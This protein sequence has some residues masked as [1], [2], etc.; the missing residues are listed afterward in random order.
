LSARVALIAL[1]LG[2]YAYFYQAGGW[3][4]NSRIDLTRAIVEQ[5]TSQIDRYVASTG[6]E[7]MTFG[8][9][10][11][12]RRVRDAHHYCDKAPGQSWMA[13]PPFGAA[14]ALGASVSG[15]TW[16]ATVVTVAVPSA[17]A[18]VLIAMLLV[19]WGV[20]DGPA[21]LA[22]LAWAFATLAFPY[23]TLFYGHQTVASL[24]VIGFAMI[25]IPRARAVAPSTL[26][27][28][29]AGAVLG[30]AV[31]VEYPAALACAIIGGYTVYTC[32]W[33]RALWVAAGALPP[34]ICAALYHW[35]LFG[36]PGTTAYTFSTQH[37]R[38]R[39]FFM[40]IGV[41]DPDALWRI[42][43]STFRGLFFTAPWLLLAIP[44]GILLGKRARGPEIAVCASIF[45]LFVWLNASLVDWNGGWALGPR[46]LVPCLPFVVLLAA[47]IL[48]PPRDPARARD[49]ARIVLLAIAGVLVA[50]A[51][52]AMLVGTAVKPEVDVREQHPWGNMLYPHFF[53]GDLAVS[54]Q[55][56]ESR[57]P[58][59]TR[60]AW[61]LGMQ[62]GL[63][64]ISSL[65]PLLLWI[66]AWS[67]VMVRAL[68]ARGTDQ[69]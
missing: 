39:G 10:A 26:R 54:T 50:Y 21:Q 29:I 24:L 2:A 66:A 36:G 17:I 61:N 9:G 19:A 8:L 31:V 55:S 5:G 49:P 57:A 63:G 40:G 52:F 11:A 51:A 27:L 16:F 23:G 12:A 41:P 32:G 45:A 59:T 3:N 58:G 30:W 60:A 43:F 6:D 35:L 15:A 56:I 13:V 34:A 53:R 69:S 46:Y 44:G 20:R 65:L 67:A 38:E 42:L 25:A 7:S 64:G 48:L 68:R 37:N 33:K 62:L 18:C 47:G 4:Q 28:V 14:R 22:A 1:V